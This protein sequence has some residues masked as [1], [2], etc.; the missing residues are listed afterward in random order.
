MGP[1][2]SQYPA[3]VGLTDLPGP[4]SEIGDTSLTEAVVTLRKRR[5]VLIVAVVLGAIYGSYKAFT[6][7][8]FY[9]AAGT[10]QV[11]NG[12]SNEYRVDLYSEYGDADTRM[13][14][15]ASILK[16]DALLATVASE[17]N[18]ANNPAFS[19]VPPGS[20][21]SLDDPNVRARVVGA[22]Q[23]GLN[24]T[25]VPHT[26]M[27]RI[28]YSSLSA[29][30]SAD[31]VN[32]VVDDY[33]QR[34]YQT[35]VE[36]TMKVSHWLSGQL[37]ELKTEVEQSQQQM[38]ELQRKL[39]VLGYDSTHSELGTSLE[40][41]LAAEGNAKVARI[42]AESR[43]RMIAGMD[44]NTIEGS[45]ETTPGTMPGELNAL[46]GQLATAKATYAE[47]TAQ[48]GLGPNNPR[49]KSL[50]AQI[51]ELT[52]EID[53]EQNRLELQ[54]KENYLAAKA[55][56]DKTEQELDAR[57]AEAYQQG[58]DLVKY[59]ILQ[60]EYEQNRALYD[61]LEQ[62]LETAKV[63]AGLEA[64]EVD[65]IDQALPPVSPTMR[66][67]SS[68]I[69]STT[70]FFLLGGIVIVFILEGLE[71]GLHNI[72]EIEAV[73]EMP[74]L[75][76]IP[77]AKRASVEQ[78]ESMTTAQ[79]NVNVLTQP[80]S[81][82]TESF[83]ALRTSL[84]LSTSGQ[85]PRFILFTSAM[86]SEGKTTMASNLACILAQSDVRVLLMDADLRRSNMHH[87]FGLTGKIGLTTVLAGTSTLEEALQHVPEIPNLDILP[88]GPLPP[89]PTEMLSSEA[90]LALMA[91]LGKMYAH[92]VIDSPP[93]LS[94]T[95]AVVLGRMVDAVVL[96][97]R[98]GKESKNVMR[99]ARDLLARSGAPMAGLVLNA[100]DVNS[101]DYYGYYG[102]LGYSY[103]NVDADTWETGAEGKAKQ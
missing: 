98:H 96:V 32:K 30:L 18:L 19:G 76:I 33:I 70:V 66:S 38:M 27:M 34:S 62:R 68:I 31:I 60:R 58:D 99:R 4:G 92:I 103:G 49:V 44:P 100:V 20:H 17:M 43:Y 57:K 89:F 61:G 79:R 3:P 2:K 45:I 56:E 6:Q 63:Q 59:T 93:V 90:M 7:P 53:T 97:I 95:D 15:E 9:E 54:A 74:S 41:L 72:Q 84:L 28:S 40:G 65:V 81:Q 87:R 42:N 24:V 47:L 8:K 52:K 23:G 55:A 39:G 73:M 21:L 85:P 94:V 71:T 1:T 51:G 102:Y 37:E 83:R 36:S 5:W 50:Q 78:M 86:P 10:I 25:L 82:F 101:P 69:L 91:R 46:R 88:S 64:L 13:N 11:H 77:Q 67:P 16:S 22:L 12:A 26:E 14:T 29:K 80:K 35:P 48:D 75:A